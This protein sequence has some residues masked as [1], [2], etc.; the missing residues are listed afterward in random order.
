MHRI[1]ASLLC[2]VP[3]TI[4]EFGSRRGLYALSRLARP[5]RHLCPGI[6]VAIALSQGRRRRDRRERSCGT[7]ARGRGSRGSRGNRANQK[8]ERRH[9][10]PRESPT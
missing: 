8:K 3:R 2:D 5:L 4:R 1:S 10:A 9:R 7:P 6:H